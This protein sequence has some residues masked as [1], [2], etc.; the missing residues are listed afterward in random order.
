M[1]KMQQAGRICQQAK[2][3]QGNISL[4]LIGFLGL[5]PIVLLMFITVVMYWP[6]ST[7]PASA[8]RDVEPSKVEKKV[9]GIVKGDTG[10]YVEISQ[11]ED[12]GEVY[13]IDIELLAE[14]EV[15]TTVVRWTKIVCQEC[16]V[17]FEKYG[18]NR[19]IS[20][21]ASHSGTLHGTTS[22]SQDTGEFTYQKAQDPG[23]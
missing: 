13:C 18:V 21:R 8:P 5:S 16:A 23:T 15:N 11:V 7:T 14:P 4:K 9:Y 6:M 22:Y 19:D 1:Q 17:I 3:E 2:T 12:T 10:Q 20:V